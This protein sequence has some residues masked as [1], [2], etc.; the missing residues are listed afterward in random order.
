MATFR[1]MNTDVA[2]F[3]GDDEPRI[4]T[5]VARVFADAERRFSRFREDSELS[6][7][8]RALEPFVVSAP[9]FDA[10]VAARRYVELTGGMFDPAIGGTLVALGY[11]RS[12]APGVLDRDVDAALP[13][14]ASF[15]DIRLDPARREVTRPFE[16][17]ID[18]GGMIK[19]RTVDEAATMLPRNGAIDAGG[20]A[21]LRGGGSEGW[22][23][24]VEDPRDASRTV[25]ALRVRDRAVATSAANRRR[26]R[27][28]G[29]ARHHLVDPRTQRSAATDLLQVTIVAASAELADVLA[30]T[31]FVL[32]ARAGQA[33][34][35]G[36]P[37]VGAVLVPITGAP[38]ICGS[39]DVVRS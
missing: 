2:V 19:G 8:N 28:A 6:R 7:L 15:L 29:T 9:M 16:V 20:D 32:G 11:D 23:V 14:P 3:A 21:V 1:A 36:R 27:V 39:V 33:F 26:W 35:E 12:F 4:A 17:Q 18:L 30:K 37:A 22:L 31:V 10:L 38:I 34:L 5:A 25:A 24:E 13:R